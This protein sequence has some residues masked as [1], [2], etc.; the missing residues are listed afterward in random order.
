MNKLL[1][2]FVACA[3][4]TTAFSW[5]WGDSQTSVA[6]QSYL[7]LDSIDGEWYTIYKYMG[8]HNCS[9]DFLSH[10]SFCHLVH[11]FEHLF[12]GHSMNHSN[13]TCECGTVNI[14]TSGEN[15]GLNMSCFNST[16][17]V[18]S[19]DMNLTSANANNTVW[20]K[21]S[22]LGL[23][24]HDIQVL[25][26]SSSYLMI[27]HPE[28]QQLFILSQTPFISPQTLNGLLSQANSLG[29]NLTLAT[30][31]A[32]FNTPATCSTWA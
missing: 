2:V 27:G 16:G 3:L 24:S 9:G 4:F 31:N 25:N 13:F 19:H 18:F 17:G 26:F 8:K 12:S 15:I 30:P 14:E 11:Y 5:S 28:H 1:L 23:C 29:F 22:F 6:E 10:L 20:E 7:N 21:S 32:T